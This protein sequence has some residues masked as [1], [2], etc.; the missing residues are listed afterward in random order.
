LE[1]S[2]PRLKRNPADQNRSI[3][4]DLVFVVHL[5]RVSLVCNGVVFLFG[6]PLF[7]LGHLFGLDVPSLLLVSSRFVSRPELRVE[8][9]RAGV[10]EVA[11]EVFVVLL[12]DVSD[13][14]TVLQTRKIQMIDLDRRVRH[15]IPGRI[16]V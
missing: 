10:V 7:D 4:E 12:D 6:D 16:P 15:C 5:Y 8:I 11:G 14:D 13:C 3:D 2:E 1:I 9:L